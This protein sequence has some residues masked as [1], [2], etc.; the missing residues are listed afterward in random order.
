[1]IKTCYS[2]IGIDGHYKFLFLELTKAFAIRSLSLGI[3]VPCAHAELTLTRMT[4]VVKNRKER[5]NEKNY[6]G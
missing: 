3:T 6:F 4:A 1:M 2:L 5:K